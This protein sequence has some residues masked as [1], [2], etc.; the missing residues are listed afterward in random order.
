MFASAEA[1]RAFFELLL[2][3]DGAECDRVQA[4]GCPDCG[5][6]LDRGDHERKLRAGGVTVDKALTFVG[7]DPTTTL[8]STGDGF[9]IA[10]N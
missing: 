9:A 7:I 3:I 5:G 6:P 2:K 4:L 10:A 8:A 1:G